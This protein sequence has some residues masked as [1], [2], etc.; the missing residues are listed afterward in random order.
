MTV[1][2]GAYANT[3]RMV[4]PAFA[5]LDDAERDRLAG[6]LDDVLAAVSA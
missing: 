1:D 2:L 3:N 4:A 5:V 6:I